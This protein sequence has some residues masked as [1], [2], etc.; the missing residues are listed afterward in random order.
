MTEDPQILYRF[1]HLQ[2]EHREWTK[3]ILTDSHLYFASPASFNDP[4]D[5]KIHY[6]SSFKISQLKEHYDSLIKSR[7]P[8]L[9]KAQRRA[10]V[11]ADVAR[12]NSKNFIKDMT[13]NMQAAVNKLGVLSLSATCNNLLLWSHYAASHTG[14]CLKFMATDTTP[15]FGLAQKVEYQEHYPEI[16]FFNH[17]P[18][19]QI[20]AFL[21]TKAIDWKYEEEWRITDHGRGPGIIKFP[22]ELLLE[23]IFGAKMEPKDKEDVLTWLAK[24]KNSVKVSQASLSKDSYSLKIEPYAP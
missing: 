15:F 4:F 24:R 23:V 3:Q 8:H 14:I 1:R 9:N 5:C 13:D 7:F 10:K 19:E 11:H 21:L 2:G 12:I 6:L 16:H 18:E 17:S 22:E 20:Q